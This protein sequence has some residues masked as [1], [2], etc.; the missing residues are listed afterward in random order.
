MVLRE[1]VAGSPRMRGGKNLHLHLDGPTSRASWK[2]PGRV[3]WG[4]LGPRT[5]K[6]VALQEKKGGEALPGVLGRPYP[7]IHGTYTRGYPTLGACLFSR[8]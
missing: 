3:G 7:R 2:D 1:K 5:Q 8:H 4:Q 6:G